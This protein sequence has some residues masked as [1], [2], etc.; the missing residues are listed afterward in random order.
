[1]IAY[2]DKGSSESSEYLSAMGI[3]LQKVER[4][5]CF[6][7]VRDS[8]PAKSVINCRLHM[9]STCEVGADL[10]ISSELPGM[11]CC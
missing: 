4:S 7:S 6:S 10:V 2:R 9:L 8:E 5:C 11:V 3:A 1:M